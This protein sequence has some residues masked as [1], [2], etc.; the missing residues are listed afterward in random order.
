M[1]DKTKVAFAALA[2]VLFSITVVGLFWL[3]SGE[4]PVGFALSYAAGLSMIFL[5]CTLPLVFIIV[6][7]S[8]GK[9]Y[10]KGFLMALLF[11]LGLTI[12]LTFYGVSVALVGKWLGMDK[13][14]R[15]MFG[16]AG[17]AAYA[18]GLSE[19]KLL[20]LHMPSFAR[21]PQFE[22]A[23][24]Y[25]KSFFMG[26]LL[27]NAGVGCPNPAFYIL[28]AYIASV[29]SVLD[30]SLLGAIHGIGRAT[31]LIFISILAILGVSAAGWI[32]NKRESIEKW[33]GWALIIVGSFLAMYGLFGMY[34]WE[35]G[36]VHQRW[37]D[38]IA[39]LVPRLAES[40][41]AGIF[42]N[43]KIIP[44]EIEKYAPWMPWLAMLLYIL[45]VVVWYRCKNKYLRSKKQVMETESKP[46]RNHKIKK[47][48]KLKKK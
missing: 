29:G 27:G 34:W 36:F 41:E 12:T 28:L 45:V 33:T 19:L 13:L 26:L 11:G 37:N 48:T 25:L 35:A 21:L 43:V 40:A 8:M 44:S 16:I 3:A 2:L 6:P 32:S 10:K 1:A 23:G 31:P 14:T 46:Q 17:I 18:F 20:R 47:K 24:D 42:F 30:G 22:H 4:H 15:W 7:L 9:G 38:L 5:P 39:Q